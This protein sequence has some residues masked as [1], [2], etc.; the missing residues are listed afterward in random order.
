M[1]ESLITESAA[2]ESVATENGESKVKRTHGKGFVYMSLRDVDDALR[3]IDHHAKRMSK[4]GLARALGHKKAEGRFRNKLDAMKAFKLADED[5]DDVV[6]TPLAID[7]LYG[8]SEATRTKARTTA[9]LSYDDFNKTF[10][11]CPKGQDHLIEYIVDYVKGKLGIVNEV[12][13]FKRLFME[14]AHFA[15]L[16]DGELNF[17]AKTVKFRHA[18]TQPG[19]EVAGNQA[20]DRRAD[21]AYEMVVGQQFEETMAMLGLQ[22]YA[23]RAEVSSRSAGKVKVAFEDGDVTFEVNRPLKVK[24]KNA[25]LILDLPEMAKALRAKGFDV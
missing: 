15:G 8:G 19:T 9:F 10:S 13:R 25:D 2:E 4:D 6:L 23:G 11:E 3:K 20:G 5:G 22:A 12:D 7:M 21:Q 18:I 1:A 14:S 17:S 16:V 24:I